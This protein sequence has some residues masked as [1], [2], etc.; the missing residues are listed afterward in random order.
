MIWLTL[1]GGTYIVTLL[2]IALAQTLDVH[3][4]TPCWLALWAIVWVASHRASQWNILAAGAIGLIFD[5]NSG[6]H[7]GV[8]VLAFGAAGFAIERLGVRFRRLDPLLRALATT[9]LVLLVM[10]LV[11]A[12]NRIVGEPV[13]P[14]TLAV[15]RAVMIAAYTAAVS[16]PV[17]MCSGWLR[18]PS[19]ARLGR[20]SF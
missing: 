12:G 11:F 14:I 17:W 16:L 20:L 2:E 7:L 15:S 6:S 19:Q 4:A 3:H 8:G 9:P 10:L 18:E 5:L 13:P 1:I